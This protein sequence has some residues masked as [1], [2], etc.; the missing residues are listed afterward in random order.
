MSPPPS[1]HL[2]TTVAWFYFSSLLWTG[3]VAADAVRD[4]HTVHSSADQA[5]IHLGFAAPVESGFFW[6]AGENRHHHADDRNRQTQTDEAR[7][8]VPTNNFK[9][10]IREEHCQRE[11]ENYFQSLHGF[12][13]LKNY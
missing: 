2:F 5:A 4:F 9:D 8:D 12:L 10:W 7:M 6:A 13:P 1:A 3:G 11:N